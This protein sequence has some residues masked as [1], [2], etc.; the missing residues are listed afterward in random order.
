MRKIQFQFLQ[1]LPHWISLLFPIL[2]SYDEIFL[3]NISQRCESGYAISYAYPLTQL[4][5]YQ[6]SA[7]YAK[8][9]SRYYE[10]STR[11]IL[12]QT[13][14]NGT[15]NYELTTN[16]TIFRNTWKTLP[17]YYWKMWSLDTTPTSIPHAKMYSHYPSLRR[18]HKTK[19]NVTFR[20]FTLMYVRWIYNE[21]KNMKSCIYLLQ[22]LFYDIILNK[23]YHLIFTPVKIH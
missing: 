17:R 6:P 19:I 3:W 8:I 12:K 15:S 5:Y 20:N 21:W 23:R 10:E 1:N 11:Q 16:G 13:T 9:H 18:K 7:P 4:L 22:H 2:Q 14:E